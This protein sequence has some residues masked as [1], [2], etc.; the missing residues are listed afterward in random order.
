MRNVT[1]QLLAEHGYLVVEAASGS[2]AMEKLATHA[3]KIDVMLTDVVMK[4]LSG[5]EL[6]SRATQSHPTLKVIYMSGYTGELIAQ[7]EAIKGEILLL[8]K[9]FTRTSLLSAIHKLL[10]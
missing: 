3:G 9:P 4:G 6:V 8:E 10:S 7:R 1:R 5:P 2:A